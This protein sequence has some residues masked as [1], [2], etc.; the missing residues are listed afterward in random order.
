MPD[1][2]DQNDSGELDVLLVEYMQRMDRGEALDREQFIAEHPDAAEGLRAFFA[3]FDAVQSAARCPDPDEPRPPDDAGRPLGVVQY[4]GD[5][6]LLREL[7]RGGMGVVYLARQTSLSRLVAVKMI[8]GKH[9]DSPESVERFRHEAEAVANL[10]HPRIV[11]IHEIGQH[12]GQHYFSMDYIAGHNL[13][14]MTRE[15][16]L[17]ARQAATYIQKVAEAVHYAHERGIIHRDLK[18]SNIL[19][20]EHDE[21]HVT[22]FG[23]A[24][25][26]AGDV[27]LTEETRVLGTPSFMPPEQAEARRGELGPPSDVYSL[28]ATL[29]DLLTGRPPFR[30]DSPLATVH[31]VSK[32]EPVPPRMLNPTIPRDLETICLKCLEKE[33]GRRYAAAAELAQDL[34][35][36]LH[37]VP[38]LARPVTRAERCW[39]WC[40][41]N[42]VVAGLAACVLITLVTGMIVSG[43][44]A[45][46]AAERAR[47]AFSESG[48]ANAQAT[49][50]KSRL[51]LAQ[52]RAYHLQLARS[53]DLSRRDPGKSLELLDDQELCPP[54]LHDFTW[55]FLH[56]SSPKKLLHL[57]AH[58]GRVLF[59]A[60]SPDIRWLITAGTDRRI[61]IW[62]LSSRQ[63]LREVQDLPGDIISGCLSP[64]GARLAVIFN[65]ATIRCFSIPD[66]ADAG[67]FRGAQGQAS[68]I[69]ISPDGRWL[70]A[71]GAQ[72]VV[73]V[74]DF[75]TGQLHTT[76]TGLTKPVCAV[77]FAPNGKRLFAGAGRE[78]SDGELMV[79]NM[80]SG[81]MVFSAA[82][83][84]LGVEGLV[85]LDGGQKCVVGDLLGT[86]IVLDATRDPEDTR[87]FEL[88]HRGGSTVRAMASSPRASLLATAAWFGDERLALRHERHVMIWN[89]KTLQLETYLPGLSH[90]P[91]A[92]AFS[93]D[94]RFLA[95][96]D[97]A[98]V[99]EIWLVDRDRAEASLQESGHVEK[100]WFDEQGK[101]LTV[102]TRVSENESDR[103]WDW[104]SGKPRNENASQGPRVQCRIVNG[105]AL[106]TLR[107]SGEAIAGCDGTR[108]EYSPDGK[109]LALSDTRHVV[110]IKRSAQDPAS[111]ELAIDR[112]SD[113][114]DIRSPEFV[115][116]P[117][118][119]YLAGLTTDD[120]VVVWDTTRNEI[121]RT[122]THDDLRQPHGLQFAPDSQSLFV[123]GRGLFVCPMDDSSGTMRKLDFPDSGGVG[124]L[125]VSPDSR[126]LAVGLWTIG[127]GQGQD[128]PL[129]EIHIVDLRSEQEPVRLSGHKG[130]VSTLVFSRDGL[131]LLS[132]GGDEFV[133][134]FDSSNWTEQA[135]HP[136][137]TTV[138][139]PSE[140]DQLPEY[141]HMLAWD[142]LTTSILFVRNG[143][144]F[145]WTKDRDAEPTELSSSES[146]VDGIVISPD[147]RTVAAAS[148][149]G[150]VTLWDVSTRTRRATLSGYEQ[151]HQ[152]FG[153]E[154]SPD[155]AQ[156]VTSG[157][158]R[159]IH[160]WDVATGKRLSTLQGEMLRFFPNG[161]VA[162]SKYR[163][164]TDV[165]DAN[166]GV[167]RDSL[168][169][170]RFVFSPNSRLAAA[171]TYSQHV[172]IWDLVAQR[173][174]ARLPAHEKGASRLTFS[175]DNR[176]LL[177]VD[178]GHFAQ[179][180]DAA[181]GERRHRIELPHQRV[182]A[183]AFSPDGTLLAVAGEQKGYR[184]PADIV[185]LD[186]AS[187]K[188][189]ATLSG[190]APFAV[191]SLAFSPDGRT[192][193]SGGYDFTVRLWDPVTGQ[194]LDTL[195]GHQGTVFALA[196]SPDGSVLASGSYD[197]TVRFWTA[198]TNATPLTPWTLSRQPADLGVRDAADADAV[199]PS[200]PIEEPAVEPV[201]QDG[202]LP[203]DPS[204]PFDEASI[205]Q[206][207]PS[208]RKL[209]TEAA[210]SSWSPD[211]KRIV[212]G[213]LPFGS[214]LQI[215]DLDNG[216]V[217]PLVDTG[218]DPAW[219]PGEGRWI[220][221]VEGDSSSVTGTICLIEPSGANRRSIGRGGFP[222]WSADGKTLFF[223][224]AENRQVKSVDAASEDLRVSDIFE[225]RWSHCPSVS[226][227]GEQVSYVANGA[228]QIV[229]VSG[230]EG[231]PL[232]VPLPST[233]F[234][235]HSWSPDGKRIA[236]GSCYGADASD[237]G[238]WV[239]Q[240]DTQRYHEVLRGPITM[241]AWSPDGR[242]LSFDLR[243]G[244]RH[245]IWVAETNDLERVA[246]E[247]AP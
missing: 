98:G 208:A 22:D 124:A 187:G 206:R 237:F 20:D 18:S 132:A 159:D 154:F 174:I 236:L 186:V 102:R 119:E 155:S 201:P 162:M 23:L 85:P 228:L 156:L 100:L 101:T 214:G 138:D 14:E 105:Q 84:P 173:E 229:G 213:R 235:F 240:L 2:H 168:E 71:G 104:A 58:Q 141:L 61:T 233:G 175:P 245:E 163:V 194:E 87:R 136:W 238:L 8:L 57:Q 10:K 207:L 111:R 125:A 205:V 164:K 24:K 51:Q 165:Y 1:P 179:L 52:R 12:E 120:T 177:T 38:I 143:G 188:H 9:L 232:A 42:P 239:L 16:P 150:S 225:M 113:S 181:T 160:I 95:T 128:D 134:L 197:K 195:T 49:L 133:K 130:K 215:L 107:D 7:G 26:I 152:E 40:R 117:N 27:S 189:A 45:A 32:S 37:G 68:A 73:E 80:A 109:Y 244:Q 96:G 151:R 169:A 72:A 77:A 3:D 242:F 246:E 202:P 122:F 30:G 92:L 13:A 29:Y 75:A 115:M 178:D 131:L 86:L 145:V 88:L 212:F 191:W 129:A 103:T 25:R 78:F 47:E 222:V 70:A 157:P 226:P 54:Q 166:T 66:G 90:V 230:Q 224:D 82:G 34:Q 64:D 190:H 53:N 106:L 200:L 55:G 11:A 185:V 221:Y 144:L 148:A 93:T 193:A 67:T 218:K 81:E 83:L 149:D 17:A 139:K 223:C 217:T 28:G 114:P 39:R 35:R 108:A 91:C 4:L 65:D 19:V 142:D 210:T 180:W 198:G 183:E 112:C 158:N 167:V 219:A 211:G 227:H 192:L 172:M 118:G 247:D 46:N 121:I 97:E 89:M 209:A 76:L 171:V 204:V 33:P 110:E 41:R 63:V 99:A 153:I 69:A 31:M 182:L 79:W 123:H 140:G 147:G 74:W 170:N 62:D 50:A 36:Y 127:Q 161:G 220:A 94:G 243:D 137:L 199:A 15:H 48:R 234:F 59:T 43:H 176:L 60:I 56:R 44:F 241:P 116:A 135:K 21:P 196:F 203:L 231:Q 5:Y 216:A 184:D 146:Q 126:T 6:E